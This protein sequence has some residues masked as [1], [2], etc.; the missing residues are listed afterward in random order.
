MLQDPPGME[1]VLQSFSHREKEKD[2]CRDEF[3]YGCQHYRLCSS[4]AG[5][6]NGAGQVVVGDRVHSGAGAPGDGRAAFDG[7]GHWRGAG[8]GPD[9][10]VHYC[11]T[12]NWAA[13]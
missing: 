1:N 9:I 11:D 2:T 4:S 3:T 6:E 13:T 8:A 5:A 10:R 7:G 12:K